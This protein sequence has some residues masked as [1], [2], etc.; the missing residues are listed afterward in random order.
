MQN[1]KDEKQLG[2]SLVL[3]MAGGMKIC[4][5]AAL[6]HITTYVL[7]EQE[8]WF[9]DEIRFVRRFLR[10]GMRA[11]DVGAN[12]GV[13]TLALAGA[14][15]ADG[16]VWAFEPTPLTADFL[17]RSLAL[18]VC[19]QVVLK[20]SAV[21]ARSGTVAFSVTNNPELNAIAT[22]GNSSSDVISVP[23]VTLDEIA[24]QEGW[25]GIDFVKLDVEGHELEAIEGG[26][27]FFRSNSP[28]LMFEIKA[29]EGI[30]LG[31]LDPLGDLG[32]EFYRL[33]PGP[34]ILFPFD[35]DEPVDGYQLNLFACK[36]DH[37][38]RLA[39]DGLLVQRAPSEVSPPSMEAWA[40]Y[41]RQ[42]PYS[43]EL[44]ARWPAK[45]GFFTSATD[46]GYLQGLAAF[47][48]S[49]DS[50]KSSAERCGLLELARARIG[51]AA[52]ESESIA[53]KLSFARVAWELGERE[54]AVRALQEAADRFEMNGAQALA[55]PF[56]APSARHERIFT[57]G[58]PLEWLRCAINEQLDRIRTYSSRYAVDNSLALLRPIIEE[59]FRAPETDRRWQL[60]RMAA[61]VQAGPQVTALLAKHSDENL[62]PKFWSRGPAEG[63]IDPRHP[64]ISN[65]WRGLPAVK[66]VDVGAMSLG[67]DEDPYV[68]MTRVLECQIIGFEPLAQECALLNSKARPGCRYLPYF[69][70]DGAE[71]TFYE[72][73]TGMTSSLYEPNTPLLAKFQNLEEVVRVIAKHRVQT[74]RLDD[75]PEVR[76]ADYLKTD[77]QG[78]ELLIFQ[79]GLEVL[80]DVLV[81]HTEVEFVPLYKGQAL[82]ADIDTFLRAQGFLF[83][84]FHGVSGRTLRPIVPDNPHGVMSQLLWADAVYVRDFME[85][86]R[87][88]AEQLLKLAAILHENYASYDLAAAALDAHDRKSGG[89]HQGRYLNALGAVVG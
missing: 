14:V 51:E 66:I 19:A 1:S 17:E 64:S 25:M 13:Y 74:R 36:P 70:G 42:A 48:D 56:L 53:R 73:N 63:G 67:E 26:S 21:S 32:Y 5:P 80:R 47:A 30:D 82:F 22:A 40:K 11:V 35:R 71:R 6:D 37:A 20:R 3:N 60:A 10:P 88:S 33:L 9:E 59:P 4:V 77:V 18:N 55:E 75:I 69:I 79:G 15:G 39:E 16:K 61:G 65:L 44:A 87:L 83:H 29:A 84:K 7:L 31:V 62:N 23:A 46:K 38:Q 72:T 41:A 76:G 12:F 89:D 78:A 54:S 45:S 86:D 2:A 34:L 52:S 27:A 68:R 81:V 58:R 50:A 43:S 24:V 85:F 8:D 49:R 28:L 57:S